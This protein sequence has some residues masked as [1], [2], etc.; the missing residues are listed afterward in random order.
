MLHLSIS[1]NLCEFIA[2]IYVCMYVFVYIYE[3]ASLGN[4][5]ETIAF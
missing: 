5:T 2:G 1:A 3:I 4:A